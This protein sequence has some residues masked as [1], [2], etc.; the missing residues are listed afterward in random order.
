MFLYREVLQQEIGLE[1]NAVR[2]KRSPYLPTVLTTQEV[3]AV[4]CH[5]PGVYQLVVKL[6]YGCGLR[7]N[8]AL[9]LRVKDIDFAQLQIVVRDNKGK[10]NCI[11]MRGRGDR[12]PILTLADAGHQYV[13]LA[14]SFS[15]LSYEFTVN[16]KSSADYIKIASRPDP[17]RAGQRACQSV[18]T[19]ISNCYATAGLGSS[20]CRLVKAP[21]SRYWL[22]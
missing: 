8:E 15:I 4:I 17:A 9:Q 22:R 1:L 3:R 14:E 13:S 19:K 12:S 18:G 21:Q 7:L 5:L 10:E 11:S 20:L 6:L 16:F 2:A